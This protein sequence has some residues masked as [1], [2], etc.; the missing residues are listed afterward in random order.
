MLEKEIERRLGEL[1]RARGGLYFKFA[2][3]NSPGVPDRLVII[4]GG[5]II[6]VELKALSGVLSAV[7]ERIIG[8]MRRQGAQVRVI[9]GW[10]DAKAF[11]EEVMP[12]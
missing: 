8:V 12:A 4:P 3:P 1:I 10:E 11:A 6:F 5:R 7:Q 9:K 2:S